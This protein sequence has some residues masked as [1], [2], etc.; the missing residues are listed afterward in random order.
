VALEHHAAIKA[1]AADFATIH[2]G[3]PG[4]GFVEPCQYVEDRRLATAGV[5]ED[6]DELA[7]V[8]VEVDVFEHRQ[9]DRAVG[10]REDLLEAFDSQKMCAHDGSRYSL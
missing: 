5:A 8:D 6:A 9:V 7:L 1:G 4:G 3:L 10:G 2:E